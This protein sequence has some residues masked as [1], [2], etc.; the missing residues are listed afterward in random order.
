[1]STKSELAGRPGNV[2]N[3]D[4]GSAP[5]EFMMVGLPL[6]G[7]ALVCTQ[8]ILASYCH[9]IALDAAVEGATAA[10]VANGG[11]SAGEAAAL[12]AVVS[13][14]P[15][16]SPSVILVR[17]SGGLAT[18]QASVTLQ[19]QVLLFGMVAITQTAEVVDENQ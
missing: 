15:N 12:N 10:A 9:N 7:I 5:L 2:G 4:R 13:Q 19:T 18:W 3:S 11:S 6:L 14:L 16:A 8:L 17:K 1:M